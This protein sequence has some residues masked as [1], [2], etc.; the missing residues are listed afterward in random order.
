MPITITRHDDVA[1]LRIGSR[2]DAY[3]AANVRQ[4]MTEAIDGTPRVIVDL[5]NV[6]FMDSTALA[7]LVQ[8]MKRCR[9]QQ[10]DLRLSGLQQPVRV[11]F[12]LTRLDSAFQIYATEAEAIASFQ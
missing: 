5:S 3:E 6:Q 11:I 2:F 10:G 8:G 1:V 7:I 12:D 9:Q 4:A